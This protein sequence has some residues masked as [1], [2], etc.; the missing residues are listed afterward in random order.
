[1]GYVKT[2][3]FPYIIPISWKNGQNSWLLFPSPL[4]SPQSLYIETAP[5]KI[6]NN[7]KVDKKIN[8]SFRLLLV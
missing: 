4:S 1:M 2:V 8:D 7:F 5:L 6:F 3:L